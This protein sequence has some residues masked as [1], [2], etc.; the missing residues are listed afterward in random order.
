MKQVGFN[1][2]G[3]KSIINDDMPTV[4]SRAQYGVAVKEVLPRP[5]ILV[6]IPIPRHPKTIK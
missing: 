4:V 6:P 1:V 5:D 2:Q 3:M